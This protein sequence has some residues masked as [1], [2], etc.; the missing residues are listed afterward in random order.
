MPP[1]QTSSTSTP[2]HKGLH[3]CADDGALIPDLAR[4][5][6]LIGCILYLNLL[7]WILPLQFISLVNL[8]APLASLIRM[9]PLTSFVI[10][11]AHSFWVFSFML[12]LPF[13]LRPSLMLIGFH[14]RIPDILLLAIMFILALPLS[15][16][17]PRIRQQ[18]IVLSLRPH[19]AVWKLL[20]VSFN[21]VLAFSLIL[22][23]PPPYL[24]LSSV[25]IR[26]PSISLKSYFP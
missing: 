24:F 1:N 15:L 23:F 5:R 12:T 16:G 6:C 2:L 20:Y 11:R 25:I 18:F 17:S 9:W 4:Y 13:L 10:V 7:I 22:M 8:S 19:I 26:P 3:L 14:A 21:G